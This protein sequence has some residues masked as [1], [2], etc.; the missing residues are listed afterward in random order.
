MG[1]PFSFQ[2]NPACKSQF[3][4][5]MCNNNFVKKIANATVKFIMIWKNEKVKMCNLVM[6][7]LKT[8]QNLSFQSKSSTSVIYKVMGLAVFSSDWIRRSRKRYSFLTVWTGELNMQ[9]VNVWT[10]S[11]KPLEEDHPVST[12]SCNDWIQIA[13][14]KTWN[15][16]E[17]H[18]TA[19][20]MWSAKKAACSK[21]VQRALLK[22]HR[23]LK[24]ITPLFS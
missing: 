1:A 10:L 3:H 4:D 23:L 19:C 18:Y 8:Y 22:T 24:A 14:K 13:V 7:N 17:C 21:H 2:K 20:F 9:T 12:T 16:T 15:K 11:V 5:F 6:L